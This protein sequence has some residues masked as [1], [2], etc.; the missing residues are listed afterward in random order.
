MGDPPT[1]YR[2]EL[3]KSTPTTWRQLACRVRGKSDAERG[4]IAA[5]LVTERTPLPPPSLGVAAKLCKTTPYWVQ[6]ALN[7]GHHHHPGDHHRN[8]NG[9]GNGKTPNLTESLKASSPAERLE[10]AQAV[11]LTWLW[12]EFVLPALNAEDRQSRTTK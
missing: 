2:L 10:A 5:E 8:G 4:Q 12:D 1:T 3:K 9:R 11:G 7:G 6:R